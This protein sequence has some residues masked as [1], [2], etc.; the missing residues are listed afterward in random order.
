M[1]NI[2]NEIIEK[3]KTSKSPEELL[4]IMKEEG[5]E[6]TAEESNLYYNYVSAQ[7]GELS[8]DELDNVSGGGCKS[9]KSG[10]TVVT[11]NCKC[12]TGLWECNLYNYEWGQDAE[13]YYGYYGDYYRRDN[14]VPRSSWYFWVQVK[15]NVCGNCRWLGFEGG[16]G[17][18]EKS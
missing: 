9:L 13:G 18:C 8:D 3:L 17:V 2:K 12:F 11:C 6:L 5:F 10:R 15:K 4:E 7:S 16:I 1:E 14:W